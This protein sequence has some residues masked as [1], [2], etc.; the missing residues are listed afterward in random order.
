VKKFKS[1][2]DNAIRQTQLVRVRLKVDPALCAAG[3]I[4]KYQGYEG[5]VLA[6]QDDIARVCIECC[7]D[8]I[9]VPSSMLEPV[10]STSPLDALKIAAVESLQLTPGNAL[11]PMIIAAN[12]PEALEA[13]L[14]EHGVDAEAMLS[15]YRKAYFASI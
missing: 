8:V 12:S 5:Y 14:R 6:E 15:V 2:V 13:Y 1:L 9:M 10:A 4:M 7:D 3:E 11:I